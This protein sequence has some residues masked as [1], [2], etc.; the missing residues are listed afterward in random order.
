MDSGHIER[1][2]GASDLPSL[3][4]ALAHATGDPDIVP[5][6]LWLDPDRALEPTGGWDD[7]QLARA[8]VLAVSGVRQILSDGEAATKPADALVP[9]LMLADRR[10]SRRRLPEDA[11]RGAC[12]HWRPAGSRAGRGQRGS[13]RR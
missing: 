10:G 3:L 1:L 11:H 8:R 6:D 9:S 4:A 2:V 7:A 13:V 12:R 5:E